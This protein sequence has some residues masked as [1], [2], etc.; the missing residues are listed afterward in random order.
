MTIRPHD[1]TDLYL[2]PVALALDRR[3]DA[4]A[5]LSA[6]QLDVDVAFA[7]DLEPRGVE[8]RRELL[9]QALV[10]LL[11]QHGWQIAWVER[12]LRLSHDDHELVLGV[13]DSVRDY[14]HG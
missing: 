7:T 6:E 13:P 9:L 3:L 4:L 1:R 10:H 2:S 12:G 8:G 11:P 5:G 14:V